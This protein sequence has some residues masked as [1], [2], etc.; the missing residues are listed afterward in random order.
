MYIWCISWKSKLSFL[1][2]FSDIQLKLKEFIEKQISQ[3]DDCY[4][5]VLLDGI[6]REKEEGAIDGLVKK[7]ARVF[8]EVILSLLFFAHISTSFTEILWSKA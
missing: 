6:K 2:F 3:L 4:A 7:W 8:N 5:T 1:I